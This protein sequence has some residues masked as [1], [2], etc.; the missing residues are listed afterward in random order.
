MPLILDY[1]AIEFTG[2]TSLIFEK[3]SMILGVQHILTDIK[4]L[5]LYDMRDKKVRI[6]K[7][8]SDLDTYFVMI[9]NN[10][11]PTSIANFLLSAGGSFPAG[12]SN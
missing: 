6:D 1:F 7:I 3:F 11:L 2:G 5:P 12:F 9:G 10:T 4:N 8:S